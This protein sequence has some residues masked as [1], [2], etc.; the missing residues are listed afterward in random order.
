MKKILLILA[1]FTIQNGQ[2]S[3]LVNHQAPYFDLPDQNGKFYNLND[4]K[5]QWLVLYFYPRDN[6]SGCTKEAINFTNKLDDF[7][8]LNAK[9]V[10]VSTDNVES[11]KEFADQHNIKFTLL[12]DKDT[13]M[14]KEYQ[15]LKK[16]PLMSF[17]KRQTY[18]INPEGKIVK[19][20]SDVTP[21]THAEEV[22]KD[23][24]ELIESSS[25]TDNS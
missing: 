10:G 15:V 22:Y 18:I 17:A 14:A 25:L 1:L 12:A 2:T 6:T 13:V 11:H 4:F 8:E 20:Y 7:T 9:I 24:S 19:H 3:S 23:L 5:D 21:S 16:I